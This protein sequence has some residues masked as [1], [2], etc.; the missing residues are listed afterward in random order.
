MKNI[1]LYSIFLAI[2]VTST[3]SGC[4][5][6]CKECHPITKVKYI[7]IEKPKHT[8]KPKFEK[9][10]IYFTN[11]NKKEYVLIPKEDAIIL[12]NNWILYK[13]WCEEQ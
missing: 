12:K 10:N 8:K 5:E 11:I 7:E 9:Y 4:C 1:K 2:L 6:K 13:N 3:F